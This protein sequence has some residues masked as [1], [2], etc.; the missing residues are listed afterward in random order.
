MRLDNLVDSLQASRAFTVLNM[1]L[2]LDQVL[3]GM[4]NT[5]MSF[6][7]ALDIL[8]KVHGTVSWLYDI[9]QKYHLHYGMIIALVLLSILVLSE[10][11]KVLAAANQCNQ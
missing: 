11:C 6:Q 8:V 1:S 5:T 2:T 3:N 7:E 9:Y 4:E 10:C